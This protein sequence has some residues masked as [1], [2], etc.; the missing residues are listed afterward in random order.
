MIQFIYF[1]QTFSAFVL[2]GNT[3]FIA[4]NHSLLSRLKIIFTSEGSHGNT[5]STLDKVLAQC[6][7]GFSGVRKYLQPFATPSNEN[8]DRA[9]QIFEVSY[10][11]CDMY[12][13]ERKLFVYL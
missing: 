2:G 10:L 8:H 4:G 1:L 11:S 9:I 3:S 7:L 5:P 12:C 13:N 6:E